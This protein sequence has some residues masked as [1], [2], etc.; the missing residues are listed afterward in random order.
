[1]KPVSGHCRKPKA[2]YLEG[3]T[4]RMLA[5]GHLHMAVAD[6]CILEAVT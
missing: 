3:V 4:E 6:W 5:R 1:V 2:R